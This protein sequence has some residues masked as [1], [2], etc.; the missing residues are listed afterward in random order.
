M[1]IPYPTCDEDAE[2]RSRAMRSTAP[3]R[4][5]P[6]PY[7]GG[8]DDDTRRRSPM[9][10]P[11]YWRPK[12]NRQWMFAAPAYDSRGNAVSVEL[13]S[14]ARVRIRRHPKVKADFNPYDPAW[15][16]S[17]MRRNGARRR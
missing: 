6:P 12:G 13:A 11:A 5:C 16:H 2:V 3:T 1:A 4:K 17:T 15:E 8:R 10:T 9:D 7:G 14:L